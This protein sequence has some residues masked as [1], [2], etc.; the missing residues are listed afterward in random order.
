MH[1]LASRL[2]PMLMAVLVF[3]PLSL[4]AA[5]EPADPAAR[6]IEL[7]YAALIDTMKNGRELGVQGR[8]RQLAPVAEDTFDLGAMARLT[9][10]PSW[11]TMSE[12]DHK[13]ITDAFG[14]LTFSNYAK[15]FAS[16]GGEQFVVDPMVKMRNE[17][18]IVESKLVRSGR[19][20]VPFNYRMRLVGD[21]WKAIDV[22]LNG[23][24]SQVALRRAD[25]SSTVA[26]SG[27]SGLVKKID[28]IVDRQM[29]GAS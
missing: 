27:A 24:V 3:L 8:Y 20:A 14:R 5:P 19:S 25:F 15:N 13:A 2:I 4:E 21:K 18:K 11:S 10:G 9:V 17:D 29:A 7:F 22:Y 16:F 12:T 26:S 1:M 23:Y 28:E 6:Q